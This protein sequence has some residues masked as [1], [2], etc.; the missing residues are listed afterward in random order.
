MGRPASR[1]CGDGWKATQPI[2]ANRA[3]PQILTSCG[4]T[5]VPRGSI[6]GRKPMDSSVGM[7][8]ERAI[9]AHIAAYCS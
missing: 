6:F 2:S 5:A 1:S 7:P 4:C 3:L 9:N 8:H